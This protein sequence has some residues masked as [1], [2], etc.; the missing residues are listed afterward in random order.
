MRAGFP[1]SELQSQEQPARAT[2][3]LLEEEAGKEEGCSN[4]WNT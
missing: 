1:L 4:I 2:V 3:W